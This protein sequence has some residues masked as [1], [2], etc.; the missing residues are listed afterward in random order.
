[1]YGETMSK[2]F[3]TIAQNGQH[4]YV[5]MAYALAMSLKLSQ[6]KY[7]KLSVIVNENEEIPEKYLP[8]F[9]KIIYVEKLQEEWKIQNKWQYF[10]LS[11][12]DET[13]VLDADMLFFNDISHWWTSLEQSDL[14]FTTAIT[15]Y[16]GEITKSDFYRKTFTKNKLP[17]LYTALFYFKKTK[18]NEEYFRAVKMM[19]ENWKAFYEKLLKEPPK[20]LS[21]D[22]IYS[23]AAKVVF[24]RRWENFL[25]F[26]HM[27]SRLQDETMIDDWNKHLPAFFTRNYGK[28]QL[29]VSNFNQIYPFHYIKKDFLNDEVIEVYENT[30][31]LL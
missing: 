9:D 22:I 3:L 5:R 6:E 18:E 12:Y 26:T 4:D 16:R 11:P 28:V 21:G 1:M 25:T 24:N 23:L 2:G 7:N 27:R 30:I 14:E 10:W 17:N 20:H 8:F 13:I 15:D 19:F 31:R 29:R